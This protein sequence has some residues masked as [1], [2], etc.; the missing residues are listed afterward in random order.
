[1]QTA[2][3]FSI[4]V[5]CLGHT[6]ICPRGCWARCI[7]GIGVRVLKTLCHMR[8]ITGLLGTVLLREELV[9]A[10]S[11]QGTWQSPQSALS[12]GTQVPLTGGLSGESSTSWQGAR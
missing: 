6:T 4:D 1:M 3:L 12:E 11:L 9:L 5:Q 2:F 10:F 7:A 8:C